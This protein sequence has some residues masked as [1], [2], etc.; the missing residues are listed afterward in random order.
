MLRNLPSRKGQGVR[1][2]IK[3]KPL[4][5]KISRITSVSQPSTLVDFYAGWLLGT[6][7]RIRG[8]RV[9]IKAFATWCWTIRR[10]G[11]GG[12]LAAWQTAF[13]RRGCIYIYVVEHFQS[14]CFMRWEEWFILDL[15]SY[16]HIESRKK[17]KNPPKKGTKEDYFNILLCVQCR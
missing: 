14:A 2:I 7:Y 4:L 10:G 9:D 15:H 8:D 12:G 17:K 6:P 5:G 1:L 16:I 11:G 13:F 3:T